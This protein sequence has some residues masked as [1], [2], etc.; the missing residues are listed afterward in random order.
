MELIKRH[1]EH[2]IIRG[3][4]PHTRRAYIADITEFVKGLPQEINHPSQ[5][6]KAHIR[7]HLESLWY[8]H[9]AK[10]SIARKMYA[11]KS[12]FKWLRRSEIIKVNPAGLVDV[13]KAPKPL[14]RFITQPEAKDIL[15]NMNTEDRSYRRDKAI[16]ETFY[17]TG[18]RCNELCWLDLEDVDFD[19]GMVYV[20]KGK[21]GN[22]RKIPIGST[23]MQA[24]KDYFEERKER[25]TKRAA[26]TRICIKCGD[27]P[28]YLTSSLGQRCYSQYNKSRYQQKHNIPIDIGQLPVPI[29]REKAP[30]N[31]TPLFISERNTRITPR[32][33][34]RIVRKGSNGKISPHTFRHS[35]ATHLLENGCDLRGIQEVLGHSSLST[36]QIYTHVA[37]DLLSKI[38]RKCHPRARLTQSMRCKKYRGKVKLINKMAAYAIE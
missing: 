30:Q 4:S 37:V 27:E 9:L 33:A 19:E 6:T 1:E 29:P 35:C 13:P 38:Y 31:G 5:V 14:P 25:E 21:G 32:Q 26:N 36:T 15:D 23:A 2:R 28:T 8:S 17:S 18:V 34:Q 22:K 3:E 12:F 20:R 10:T 7:E 11:I 24:I 16:L